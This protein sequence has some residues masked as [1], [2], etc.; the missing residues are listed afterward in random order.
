[1]LLVT[2]KVVVPAGVEL[3]VMVSVVV[4]VTFVSLLSQ[5]KAA[6]LN[7]KLAPVGNPVTE[8]IGSSVPLPESDF[9][10]TVK[11]VPLALVEHTGEGDWVPTVIVA[12]TL[13]TARAESVQ[14]RS[15]SNDK[16][17][18]S[19]TI[20]FIP[21]PPTF[22]SSSSQCTES[23]VNPEGASTPRNL[24]PMRRRKF[25]WQYFFPPPQPDYRIVLLTPTNE[26]GLITP[27]RLVMLFISGH[28]NQ[29]NE[30]LK[31]SRIDSGLF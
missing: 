30:N 15:V 1:M 17:Q 3:V 12:T 5:C 20:R 7:E 9:T 16:Q 31:I 18:Q 2:V 10:E 26:N 4:L 8:R 21:H 27:P 22:S 19:F 13:E 29:V 6:G 24:R 25:R 14:A 23:I 28:P 11:L